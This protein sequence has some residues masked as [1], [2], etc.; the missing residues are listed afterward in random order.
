MDIP[1]ID[2]HQ[3]VRLQC[4]KCKV[5]CNAP[6]RY[7]GCKH[8]GGNL[9]KGKWK[10]IGPEIPPVAFKSYSPVGYANEAIG[11][12]EDGIKL[13]EEMQKDE[14]Y[15]EPALRM[16]IKDKERLNSA[17]ETLCEVLRDCS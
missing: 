10:E 6:R 14:D 1:I 2:L 12:I 3:Y 11:I 13:I 4:N 15:E 7:T 17:K 9:C 16:L 5:E 8:G